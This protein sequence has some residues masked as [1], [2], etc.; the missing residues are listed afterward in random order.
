MTLAMGSMVGLFL[1][2]EESMI[3][4]LA[5]GEMTPLG[6]R[7]VAWAMM[8]FVLGLPGYILVKMT[9]PAF[10]AAHDTASPVK[11]SAISLAVN[12][13]VNIAVVWALIRV[14]RHDV[15]HVG[16]ALATALGGYVN[17]G[18]Q[19]RWLTRKNV[20][21][22]DTALIRRDAGK[23]LLVSAMMAVVVLLLKGLV[24]FDPA[25]QVIPQVLWLAVVGGV[26]SGVFGLAV[27][28]VGLLDMLA[29]LEPG[30]R[31]LRRLFAVR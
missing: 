26:A 15:A 20:L 22:V 27:H 21:D 2:A 14:G 19:W 28:M 3:T 10:F 17:A 23:M 1:L 5:H 13:V 16:I 31:R 11:A 4:L 6:A 7:Q 29:L 24:P 12:L 18:L 8:G 9:A 30:M 25:W